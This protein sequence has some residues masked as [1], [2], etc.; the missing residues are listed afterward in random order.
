MQRVKL[1]YVRQGISAMNIEKSWMESVVV[2]GTCGINKC[3]NL[4]TKNNMNTYAKYLPNVFLAKCEESHNRDEEIEVE[5]RYWTSNTCIVHNLIIE[6]WGY[7][8]YSVTRADWFNSQERARRKAERLQNAS[9]NAIDRSNK[10]YES[11][12]EG[13]EFLALAEPIKIGHHSE[14]RHRALIERNHKRMRKSI[15]EQEKADDYL[16][17]ADY[18]EKQAN[19][20]DLSMPESIEYFSYKFEKAKEYHEGLKDWTIERDHSYSLAYASK[21]LKEIQK[22]LEIAKKLWL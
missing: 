2:Y 8:Y 7:F 17:R 11:S 14:W 6:K 21:E 20:I 1:K 15:E 5:T 16:S 19:K 12:N 22:K 18:W 13:K 10:A 9:S 3:L 4:L